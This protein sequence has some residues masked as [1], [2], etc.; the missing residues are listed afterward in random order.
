MG[1]PGRFVGGGIVGGWFVREG[2]AGGLVDGGFTVDGAIIECAII[3]GCVVGEDNDVSG[4]T[5]IFGAGG[6]IRPGKT[7][8]GCM[9]PRASMTMGPTGRLT[10]AL[11]AGGS[12]RRVGSCVSSP[13]PGR[14]DST[15]VIA[16]L[17]VVARGSITTGGCCAPPD[18]S[19]AE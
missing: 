4:A 9:S 15:T 14:S 13:R 16:V 11:T 18:A 8:G 5:S 1:V 3:D 12:R 17:D 6:D 2:L 10:E 19:S 7:V